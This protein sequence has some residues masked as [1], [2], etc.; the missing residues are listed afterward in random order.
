MEQFIILDLEW[1]TAFSVKERRYVNEI[2]EFGALKLD[3]NLHQLS[4]FNA[5]VHPEI[6]KHVN[7]RVK[8]LTGIQDANLTNAKS[9]EEVCND[10]TNWIGDVEHSLL[11]T[12]DETDV[13]T[14]IDNSKYYLKTPYLPF[15]SHYLNVQDVFMQVYKMPKSQRVG[16]SNAAK[17]A[18]IDPEQF[19][20]HRALGD[21]LLTA[22]C[23][24]KINLPGLF[25]K[26][27]HAC[28]DKFY[29]RLLFKPYIIDDLNDPSIDKNALSCTCMDCGTEAVKNTEWKLVNNTFSAFFTCP[30][31]NKKYRV[32][33]QFK[34]LYAQ[35]N[36][37]KQVYD[38]EKM[39]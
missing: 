35:V 23:M 9:F 7:D 24:R 34:R 21:C 26:G 4:D 22:E 20:H 2:I 37:N 8:K 16:L 33:L 12:W 32:N 5:F 39:S 27:M 14:L 11:I 6:S 10:F 15:L 17:I 19:V 1:N 29:N 38:L 28:D 3:E 31:C 13:R 36:I 30:K 25:E 18:G